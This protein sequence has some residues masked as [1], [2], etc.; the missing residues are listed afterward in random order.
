MKKSSASLKRVQNRQPHS[1][2]AVRTIPHLRNGVS[3][4]LLTALYSY[5]VLTTHDNVHLVIAPLLIAPLG[6][7]A[8]KGRP[9]IK[10]ALPAVVPWAGTPILAAAGF[11][12]VM[13]AALV[14]SFLI[15]LVVVQMWEASLWLGG[16][17]IGRLKNPVPGPSH[18]VVS[19]DSGG[20]VVALNSKSKATPERPDEEREYW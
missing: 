19:G 4:A 1:A 2:A 18:P 17:I 9:L 13:E 15:G 14:H 8:F 10:K 20:K 16:Y 3:L 7:H 5:V 11:D 6:Y 12:N